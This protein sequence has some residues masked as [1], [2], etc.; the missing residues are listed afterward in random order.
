M[1]TIHDKKDKELQD[2]R[3]ITLNRF[4]YKSE[5]ERYKGKRKKENIYLKNK[6]TTNMI[7]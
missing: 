3:R 7:Y 2:I 4:S 6:L 5:A 1:G